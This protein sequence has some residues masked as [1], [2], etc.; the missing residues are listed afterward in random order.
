[1]IRRCGRPWRMMMCALLLWVNMVPAAEQT[2]FKQYEKYAKNSLRA[3]RDYLDRTQVH[4]VLQSANTATSL[5]APFPYDHL[6]KPG[7]IKFDFGHGS[8][9]EAALLFRAFEVTGD[10][11]FLATGLDF[12][13][14]LLRSQEQEGYWCM[15]YIVDADGTIMTPTIRDVCRIQDGHQSIPFYLLLYAYK[16]TQDKRYYDAAVRCAD[17]VLET[18]NEN[19]SWPD[20]WDFSVPW[21]KG[22]WSTNRGVR[23]G[24]SYNDMAT[25]DPMRMMLLMYHITHDKKYI[26]RIPRVGQWLFT[27]R[28]GD[29]NVTGWCQQYGPDDLPVLARSFELAV[30]EPRTYSRFIAPM[31][32]WFYALTGEKRYYDLARRGYDWLKKVET[33][34]G[35][36]YQYLPDGTPV[37]SFQWRIYRYDQ[38]SSWPTD[39]IMGD[40]RWVKKYSREKV[41]LTI[42]RQ[43]LDLV[44][45]AGL[46]GL[47]QA[48]NGSST[49]TSDQADASRQ[50]ALQRLNDPVR[51]EK[52]KT[53]WQRSTKPR[54]DYNSMVDNLQYIYDIQ[55][56]E[57]RVSIETLLK[58]SR[59]FSH[60]IVR[61]PTDVLGDWTQS[62]FEVKN[63]LE[64]PWF[65]K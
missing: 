4:G 12:C 24:G 63:W 29:G 50:Q 16:L 6:V 25:S 20:F 55:I 59:G 1:M 13:E 62:V 46:A 65:K 28:L 3:W 23:V 58:R 8:G 9:N 49:V 51:I 27:T 61:N 17:V 19:G 52:I 43:F 33:N 14:F 34:E 32:A 35:W 30:I 64:V 10:S 2:S 53:L 41:D 31:C 39:N 56:I 15:T 5:D 48:I 54:Q 42:A 21:N 44:G 40:H 22:P 7:G 60:Q 45:A 11:A 18:Q 47:R 37:F 57:N 26:D 36:A 38:P